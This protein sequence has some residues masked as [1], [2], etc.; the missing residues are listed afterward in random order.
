MERS[1]ASVAAVVAVVA[2]A[3]TAVVGAAAVESGSTGPA[4]ANAAAANG[5]SDNQ[6][7]A[8]GDG[9]RAATDAQTMAGVGACNF[10]R[11]YD[12]TIDSVVAIQSSAGVGSGF[13]YRVSND[14]S[15]V[16]T[17]AHVVGDS[18]VVGV[19]F[20]GGES[21]TARVVGRDVYADLSVV[22]VNGTPDGVSALPIARGPAEHGEYVAALGNPF[23]LEQTIT[24]G[25]VSGTN[26]T[27]PTRLGF[28]IPNVVQTDAPISPGNSGGPLVTC[29]GT[30]V[31]VDTA[32]IEA[33]GAQN[34]G[35][36]ISAST[37]R[38]IVPALIRSG[39]YRHG[40]LGV[41]LAPVTPAL[42]DALGENVSRGAY[43]VSVASGSPAAS[44]LQGAS[45][46]ERVNG[47][48]VPVGGDVIVGVNGRPVDSPE[49]LTTY[50]FTNGHPGDTVTLTVVRDGQRGQVNVTLG[51][52]PQPSATATSPGPSQP[53]P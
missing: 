20:A 30:V 9:A 53:G 42:G 28:Q 4:V 24:H 41:S 1:Y 31:G 48:R 49:D 38:E 2:L 44:T 12:R 8:A 29:N 21:V 40:F 15:Y 5:T 26:R 3:V 36:A 39:S 17:N 37:V 52:R 14:T 11:T 10:R 7:G 25:I 32:G 16:V 13:V 22:R 18:G 34:I 27:L 19:N 43:V 51:R 6:S 45:R 47:T 50:L 35:F 33:Q 46:Y 23:G